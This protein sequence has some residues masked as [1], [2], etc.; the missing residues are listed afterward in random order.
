[1]ED[2][3]SAALTSEP[4][5]ILKMAAWEGKT[6]AI[7]LSTLGCWRSIG[8]DGSLNRKLHVSNVHDGV[9]PCER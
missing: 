5:L 7:T 4:V 9:E 1:M 3:G 2:P 8:V 6:V